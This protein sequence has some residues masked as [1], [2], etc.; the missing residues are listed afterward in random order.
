MPQHPSRTIRQ[1]QGDQGLAAASACKLGSSATT[2]ASAPSLAA[3]DGGTRRAARHF[4][5]SPSRMTGKS[6]H[7]LFSQDHNSAPRLKERDK[8][9]DSPHS[10]PGAPH[11]RFRT[12]DA[13]DDLLAF[14]AKLSLP[15][16]HDGRA[17][18]DMYPVHTH[19]CQDKCWNKPSQTRYFAAIPGET[20]AINVKQV[21]ADV[22]LDVDYGAQ[23]YVDQGE[24]PYA[25]NSYA[26]APPME[27]FDSCFTWG[28]LRGPDFRNEHLVQ[29]FHKNTNESYAFKFTAPTESSS[30]ARQENLGWIVVYYHKVR[31]Y[32]PKSQSR[33]SLPP[34]KKQKQSAADVK[35]VHAVATEAGNTVRSDITYDSEWEPIFDPK[36][37]YI[38]RIRYMPWDGLLFELREKG[39]LSELLPHIYR[40]IPIDQLVQAA[41]RRKILEG[42]FNTAKK[43]SKSD[44]VPLCHMVKLINLHFDPLAA[45]IMCSDMGIIPWLG[46]QVKSTKLQGD[47]CSVLEPGQDVDDVDEDPHFDEKLYGLCEFYSDTPDFWEVRR[48][49]G[50][51]TSSVG[52]GRSSEV[53][54]RII[55]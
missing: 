42:L 36:P 13:E 51:Q 47:P 30:D 44:F 7:T 14:H 45:R 17:N 22:A 31:E 48:I 35:N 33:N 41:M 52:R 12:T 24:H 53:R 25:P 43:C 46:Q 19:R 32:R 8:R 39:E 34:S 5:A 29:G 18:R 28:T 6:D 23:V 50:A 49:N 54:Q 20:F 26:V 1:R 55:K 38:S 10:R 21:H 2:A 4:R 3:A 16:L 11:A 40:A 15:P 27:K 37:I 9:P